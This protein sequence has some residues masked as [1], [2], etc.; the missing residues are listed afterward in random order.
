MP[1]RSYDVGIAGVLK[2]QSIFQFFQEAAGN[3]ATHLG[4]G[5]EA[6]Q[7]IGLVWVLSRIKAEIA[8]LPAW[9]DEVVV[10][11]WPKGAD[12]L[13]ALRDFLMSGRNGIVMVRG[14]SCWLLVSVESLRPRRIESL[15]HSFPLND[16][17]HA[18][19]ESLDRIPVPI[20]LEVKYEK[21]VMA[22]DL[23][24]NNH[25][26]NTEYVRWITDCVGTDKKTTL[27][28]RSVQINYLEE[29]KLGETIVFSVGR[30]DTDPG[31]VFVEGVNAAKGSKVVQSS[32]VLNP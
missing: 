9:G 28:L 4:V 14:T 3:H 25:V 15:P 10:T 7:S 12:R 18:L 1:V 29:A 30:G 32:I 19:Q 22:S 5:Y 11:T 16:K 2:P 13:F 20:G 27:S 24:L 23:D 6:L 17:E 21:R 26:N 8:N 31:N